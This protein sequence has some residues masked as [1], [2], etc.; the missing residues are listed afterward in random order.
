MY[1]YFASELQA[2]VPISSKPQIYHGIRQAVAIP[3]H[4]E[5]GNTQ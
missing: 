1:L 5:V 4:A 3:Q 2:C